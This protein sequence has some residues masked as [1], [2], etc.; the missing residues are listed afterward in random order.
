MILD[1]AIHAAVIHGLRIVLEC[2]LAVYGTFLTVL[3]YGIF[4]TKR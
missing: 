4:R 1:P 2:C 3:A